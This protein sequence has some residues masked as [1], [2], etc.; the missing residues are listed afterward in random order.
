[1]NMHAAIRKIA[2][3]GAVLTAFTWLC[4]D[5]VLAPA[6][7]LDSSDGAVAK[8]ERERL[9]PVLPAPS[10]RNPLRT[11]KA[12]SPVAA[13]TAQA[14]RPPVAAGQAEPRSNGKSLPAPTDSSSWAKELKLR[15][16]FVSGSRPSALINRQLCFEGDPV[17]RGEGESAAICK[18]S[19]VEAN[20]VVLATEDQEIQLGYDGVTVLDSSSRATTLPDLVRNLSPLFTLFGFGGTPPQRVEEKGSD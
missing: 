2:P 8:L 9:N 18:V 16:T 3:L 20:R 13:P 7:V 4:W 6:G 5:H 1:M 10:P 17:L 11:A 12:P 19:R 14:V 15:G